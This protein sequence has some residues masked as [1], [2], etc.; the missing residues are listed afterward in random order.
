MAA[1]RC[2]VMNSSAKDGRARRQP[3]Q[4]ILVGIM[5]IFGLALSFCA[6]LMFGALV[7]RGATKKVFR[8]FP[9]FY[10]YICYAFSGLFVL[11][12]IYWFEPR[13]YSRASWL[14]YL[15]NALAEFAVLIEI[16][17][18]IFRPFVVIRSLGRALTVLIS[19]GFGLLY[20]LPTILYSTGR[21]RALG[22]FAL[23]T[24]ITKAVIIAVLLYVARHYDSKLGRNVGGLMLGFAIYVAMDVSAIAGAKA[25]GS[26]LF[27]QVFWVMMP[28]ASA[29]CAL[30][31]TISLWE[32]AP[33]PSEQMT[34]R[35]RGNDLGDVA[36][37]LTHFNSELTK[38]LHK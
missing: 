6:L 30:V 31:W 22:D 4:P 16:S 12:L 2:R 8:W 26:G 32:I 15:I 24:S 13:L 29:L 11:Y 14:N 5:H 1:P 3:C 33:P 10:S 19:A 25:Y 34:S 35:L 23:R 21:S 9:Y 18:H 20:V 17:D 37:G 27:A 7:L 28:L 36:L 38:I